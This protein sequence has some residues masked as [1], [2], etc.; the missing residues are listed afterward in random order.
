MTFAGFVFPPIDELFVW[1]DFA[2]KNTNYAINKTS[3]L[4]FISSALVILLFLSVSRRMKLVPSG[5]QNVVE[6]GW[7]L[8]DKGITKDVVGANA[9]YWATAYL[10]SLFFFI[11]SLNMW[12]TI[13]FIQFP[14]T[15]RMAIPAFLAL[16]TYVIFLFVGF[17]T[18]G[19]KYLTSHL[20]PPG[21]PI[22]LY[23]LVTPIEFV[24]IFLVRPFS[25]AVRLLANM[26]A[27]HILLT[28]M[29]LLTAYAIT[30]DSLLTK[31]IAI[32]PFFMNIG[33]V[34][35]ELLVAVLQAYIFTL[36][37]AVYIAE[38]LHPDH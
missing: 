3:L 25:L 4:V 2:F 30:S 24:S 6:A 5:M 13:P 34:G 10:G 23:I 16:M 14:P 1:P 9:P 28:A 7:D 21:V 18:S 26:M 20:F 27:G 8:V 17:K 22:F 35:F 31:F 19:F 33:I 12:S 15:A 37:S 36:L 29:A 32:G 38:A 11:L